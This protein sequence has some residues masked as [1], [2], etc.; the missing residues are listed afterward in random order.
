MSKY[1]I[2]V[3]DDQKIRTR[4]NK[5]TN[6]LEKK[7]RSSTSCSTNPRVLTFPHIVIPEA[8]ATDTPRGSF[9]LPTNYET[10][11]RH[12][13]EKVL[14]HNELIR[15]YWANELPIRPG[16]VGKKILDLGCGLGTN[17][18]ILLSI[19]SQHDVYAIDRAKDF[20]SYAATHVLNPNGNL[21][22]EHSAF[23]DFTKRR[24]DFVLCSH[25][26]QYIDTALT[27][28]LKKIIES[29]AVGGEAW[30]VL[31]EE[32]GINKLV[33]ASRPFLNNPSPY[34]RDWFVHERIRKILI[35]LGIEIRARKISSHFRAP[36]LNNPTEDDLA[37]LNFILLDGFDPQ[38]S[39]L[40][41]LLVSEVQA[42]SRSDLIQ[43]DIGITK[44]R[45]G[46]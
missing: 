39:E 34:L 5:V 3:F 17:T 21:S 26:L 15:A 18:S 36:N 46:P 43:H 12:T 32:Y 20:L 9:T 38:N 37:L 10:Y 23:E 41:Q 4:H 31:Q 24:F 16:E 2:K 8:T 13:N 22:V 30:I 44:I 40:V 11:V 6:S 7:T 29:L 33:L 19:F 35:E 1:P 28:F 45:R 25:V 14:L 27:P 42:L